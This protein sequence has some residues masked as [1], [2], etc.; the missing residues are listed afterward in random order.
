MKTNK[1]ALLEGCITAEAQRV[2]AQEHP[3]I[4]FKQVSGK[5][6]ESVSVPYKGPFGIGTSGKDESI[7]PL[8][9]VSAARSMQHA[10][11]LSDQ[12]L[13]VYVTGGLHVVQPRQRGLPR[14]ITPL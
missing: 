14:L 6:V 2:Y 12:P 8:I 3:N 10:S 5:K 4:R 1:K 7:R 9:E 13:D 11:H